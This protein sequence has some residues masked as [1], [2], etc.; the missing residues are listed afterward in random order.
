LCK[1]LV[2]GANGFVGTA[3]CH[4]LIGHGLG[5][6]RAVRCAD[7]VIAPGEDVVVGELGPTT[8]W[9]QA[10]QGVDV[11]IHLAARAHVMRDAAVDPLADYRRVNVLGTQGLAQAAAAAGVRRMVFLS[12]IKVNGEKTAGKP[13]TEQ[14][15]PHP[16]DAYG[17]SKWEA[18]QVLLAIAAASHMEAVVLRPPLLYGPGVKGNF[19][20]LMR[21]IDRG[22]PLPL[23][24]IHNRRSLLYVG[25]LIDALISCLDHPAAAGKTYL[26]ADNEGVSTPDLIR[27]IARALR[28]PARLLPFP[29]PLL[30]LAGA[31]AGKADSVARLLGSLQV[32]TN[33]IRRELG[34]QPCTDM[35]RGLAETARWYHQH[36]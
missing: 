2:T 3:L 1:I 32:D 25:S 5:A 13:Y 30:K 23:A 31:M 34:W 29:P 17:V 36:A 14:D 9:R 4:A 19:L 7:A 16:Q 28:K 6:R 8:A 20:S 22:V 35:T 15:L 11:V 26:V 33:R 10:L 12:S 21:T 18:E 27:G 24:S